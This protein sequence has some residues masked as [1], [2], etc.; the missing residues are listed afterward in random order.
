MSVPC[1]VHFTKISQTRKSTTVFSW[2]FYNFGCSE[3][4]KENKKIQ[5]KCRNFNENIHSQR[6]QYSL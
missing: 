6:L 4:K 1:N 3:T 5:L 2:H